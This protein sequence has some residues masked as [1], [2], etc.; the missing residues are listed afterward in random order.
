MRAREAEILTFEGTSPERTQRGYDRGVCRAR[1][2]RLTR[3]VSE[4]GLRRGESGDRRT[5]AIICASRALVSAPG[6]FRQMDRV[7]R[8][9]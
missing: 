2:S 5:M 8:L 9:E 4:S 3:T 1:R 6:K 7:Q